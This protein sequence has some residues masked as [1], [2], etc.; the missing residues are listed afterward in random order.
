M[1]VFLLNTYIICFHEEIRKYLR[2]SSYSELHVCTSYMII[3]TFSLACWV[4]SD[5]IFSYKFDK[6]YVFKVSGHLFCKWGAYGQTVH[7]ACLN[8]WNLDQSG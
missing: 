1:K 6:N 8:I 5:I 7:T 4:I 2:K 3:Y